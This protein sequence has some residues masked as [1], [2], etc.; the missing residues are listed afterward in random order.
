MKV[1][2]LLFANL[3]RS[4]F[5]R[6][7]HRFG[8]Q[9]KVQIHHIIPLEWKRHKN[10]IKNDYNINEGY[11]LIF[12]PSKKGKESIDTIRRI[13]D[14]GHPEY[15]KYVYNLLQTEENPFEI[16]KILRNKLINNKEIPW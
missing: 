12:L 6:Y 9:E 14:G 15:N 3:F 13:H 1:L 16:S 5:I 2:I 8:L 10:L 11:N 4:D 7:K